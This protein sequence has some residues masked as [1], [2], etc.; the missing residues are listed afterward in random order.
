M[1]AAKTIVSFVHFDNIVTGNGTDGKP[2][3]S[4]THDQIATQTAPST[5]GHVIQDYR[6]PLHSFAT[7]VLNNSNISWGEGKLEGITTDTYLSNRANSAK[8]Q[9]EGDETPTGKKNFNASEEIE[10]QLKVAFLENPSMLI[11]L[12]ADQVATKEDEFKEESY[13]D[14]MEKKHVGKFIDMRMAA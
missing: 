8:V 14:R 3:I 1:Q 7:Q 6:D 11:K 12:L 5:D 4:L 9:A 10:K 2:R 13:Y